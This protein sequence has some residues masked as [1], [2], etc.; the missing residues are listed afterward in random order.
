M[1][2]RKIRTLE[3]NRVTCSLDA[4]DDIYANL[5]AS[6]LELILVVLD[7]AYSVQVSF[8]P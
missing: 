8:T 6:T 3:G 5:F 2:S 4:M 7:Y 1:G